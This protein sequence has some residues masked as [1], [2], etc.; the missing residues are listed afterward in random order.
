MT[1]FRAIVFPT[2]ILCS[3]WIGLAI[4]PHR[5]LTLTALFLGVIP[6]VCAVSGSSSPSGAR[7]QPCA[8]EARL[9]GAIHDRR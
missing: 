9:N 7:R 1:W 6:L 3:L 8:E 5:H 2:A 4:G